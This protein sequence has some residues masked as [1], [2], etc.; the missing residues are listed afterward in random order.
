MKLNT[1]RISTFAVVGILFVFVFGVHS[2]QSNELPNAPNYLSQKMLDNLGIKEHVQTPSEI[3]INKNDATLFNRKDRLVEV[4]LADGNTAAS[5][6]PYILEDHPKLND[7]D[8]Y[9][10]ALSTARTMRQNKMTYDQV[11]ALPTHSLLT[12]QTL[13]QTSLIELV[14]VPEVI[15]ALR[16][17]PE[18]QMVYKY[19]KNLRPSAPDHIV[20]IVAEEWVRWRILYPEHPSV[21]QWKR[22]LKLLAGES[23]YNPPCITPPYGASGLA[24][25]LPSTCK[26][27]PTDLGRLRSNAP[28]NV[29][30]QYRQACKLLGSQSGGWWSQWVAD[31]GPQ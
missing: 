13:G 20:Q 16:H 4:L 10:L 5:L 12:I 1:R 27:F 11:K 18:Y 21:L 28:D 29:R 14:D 2:T 19:M 31:P 3:P 23:G 24:Q 9:D 22:W 30:Y 17:T 8:A 6:I 7:R 25:F 15:K 26:W